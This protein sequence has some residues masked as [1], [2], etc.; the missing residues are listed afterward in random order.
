M[1]SISKMFLSAAHWSFFVGLYF[2]VCVYYAHGEKTRFDGYQ[3]IR[4]KVQSEKDQEVIKQLHESGEFDFWDYPRDVMVS[5]N[6]VKEVQ[7]KLEENGVEH[8][9]WI[10]N[11]QEL[12]ENQFRKGEAEQERVRRDTT[13][14][15]VHDFDYSVYHRYSELDQ[16]VKNTVA[17]FPGIAEE[18]ILGKSY[19]KRVIRGIKIGKPSSESK[20]AMWIHSGIHS[21]EWISPATNI[22][23]TNQFLEDYG[24]NDNVTRILDKYDMYILPTLNPDGYDYTWDVNRLWRKTRSKNMNSECVGTDPNRNW[25]VGFGGPGTST[26][27]CSLIYHGPYLHSES[28]V[29]IATDFILEKSKT[30]K[31]VFFMDIHSYSQYYLNPHGYKYEHPI[32]YDDH[33]ALGNAFA[34]ATEAVNGTEY[35]VGTPPDILYIAS[36]IGLDWGYEG[37]GIK[38]SGSLELRDQ[39]HYGFLLPEDQILPTAKETYVGMI[40]VYEFI[41]ANP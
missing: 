12:I 41:M 37:A 11:V 23:M 7:A 2:S 4:I 39:G 22:W 26:N 29:K 30:Q 32:D 15:N 6:Q 34:A 14:P 36:G 33:M 5:P 35:I 19:E 16:W 1:V 40:A 28:E 10:G 25:R 27:P 31:F 21:R 13:G 24:K 38:Y 3:V 17:R 9:F 8:E 20:E 18:F